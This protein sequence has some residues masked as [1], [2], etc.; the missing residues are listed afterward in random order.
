MGKQ[1]TG[2][3]RSKQKCQSRTEPGNLRKPSTIFLIIHKNNKR[4]ICEVRRAI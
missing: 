3:R 1:D 4:E 2:K